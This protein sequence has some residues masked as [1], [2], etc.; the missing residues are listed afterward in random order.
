MICIRYINHLLLSTPGAFCLQLAAWL[1]HMSSV[2]FSW[3]CTL[4]ACSQFPPKGLSPISP[5]LK[6]LKTSPGQLPLPQEERSTQ[7]ECK[8]HLC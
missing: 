1:G 3:C 8:E 6:T 4:N 5:T 7:Q 2:E